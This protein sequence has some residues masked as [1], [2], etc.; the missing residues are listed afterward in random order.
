[1]HF[2]LFLNSM[3]DLQKELYQKLV[4]QLGPDAKDKQA[5]DHHPDALQLITALKKLCS[6]PCLLQDMC[7]D[8][9]V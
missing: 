6:H 4:N 1:M 3:T 2:D 7:H 5:S 9:E 8:S